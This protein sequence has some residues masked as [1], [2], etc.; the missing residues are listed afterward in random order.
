MSF[1][2]IESLIRTGLAA[3]AIAA[4]ACGAESN[5]IQ[6]EETTVP[7]LTQGP[8]RELPF[9]ENLREEII[10]RVSPNVVRVIRN[11]K[12][13]YG[14]VTQESVDCS[15]FVIRNFTGIPFAVTALHCI[16][17][18]IVS[19][20]DG[21]TYLSQGEDGKSIFT[22]TII[23]ENGDKFSGDDFSY[24]PVAENDLSKDVLVVKM[25]GSIDI[26]GLSINVNELNREETYY[27]L[28]LTG[29]EID[30]SPLHFLDSPQDHENR[31]INLSD[32]LPCVPGSSGSA[33]VNSVGE[34]VG[35]VSA[36]TFYELTEEDVS[37]LALES[38][39]VGRIIQVC[40]STSA[41]Q[42]LQL[43]TQ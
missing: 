41:D 3:S 2:S 30:I 14:H 21:E 36:V 31:F 26:A 33:I 19:K 16:P 6:T 8:F 4:G 34:V 27:S 22:A 28:K 40:H 11:T 42:I 29:E 15:G 7:T 12:V 37:L 10:N 9:N 18:T 24:H 43:Y 39:H 25:Q 32:G 5:N 17:E 35:V 13:G 20:E 38:I 23:D 1:R